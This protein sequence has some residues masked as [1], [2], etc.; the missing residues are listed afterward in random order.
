M[1]LSRRAVLAA[2]AATPAAPA[3]AQAAANEYAQG[4]PTLNEAT[5]AL[6]RAL[7]AAGLSVPQTM[8]TQ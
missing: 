4:V 6:Q 3:V 5:D 8:A 2:A 7:L 1:S